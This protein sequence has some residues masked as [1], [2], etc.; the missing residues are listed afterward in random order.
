[1]VIGSDRTSYSEGVQ[2]TRQLLSFIDFMFDKAGFDREKILPRK[3]P[4]ILI[5][6]KFVT[7]VSLHC[8]TVMK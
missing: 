1:M 7:T 2:D 6:K 3:D 5:L 4:N 8:N